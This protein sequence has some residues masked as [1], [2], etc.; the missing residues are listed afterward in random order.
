ML[1]LD[2]KGE[3]RMRLEGYLPKSDFTAALESSL[4]R[5]AFVQ[6]KY[7]DADRWYGDVVSN[8]GNSHFAPEAMYWRA[9]AHYSATHDPATLGKVAAELRQRY[10]DSVWATKATPW[11]KE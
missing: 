2:S 7:D 5:L 6:K 1:V 4:G 9:V 8:L 3:E 10:P 11:L